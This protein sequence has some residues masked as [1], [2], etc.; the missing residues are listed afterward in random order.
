[1]SPCVVNIV[2]MIMHPYSGQPGFGRL[3]AG[4]ITAAGPANHPNRTSTE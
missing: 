2:C 1:M 4:V 3:A